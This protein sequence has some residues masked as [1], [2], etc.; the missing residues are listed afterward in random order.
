MQP[1]LC[2]D[3]GTKFELVQF[4]GEGVVSIFPGATS[5]KLLFWLPDIVWI[6]IVPLPRHLILVSSNQ[7]RS[8]G[9]SFPFLETL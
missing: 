2:T 8:S 9:L 1:V 6:T 7:G 5:R 3:F 4:Q